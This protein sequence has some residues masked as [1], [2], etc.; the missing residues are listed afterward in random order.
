MMSL[1]FLIKILGLNDRWESVTRYVGW[2]IVS[3]YWNLL[4]NQVVSSQQVGLLPNAQILRHLL[5]LIVAYVS[6]TTDF[7]IALLLT[8][9]LA[10]LL[11][12]LRLFLKDCLYFIWFY[13][14]FNF[15]HLSI[16]ELLHQASAEVF[17]GEIGPDG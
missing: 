10:S 11:E 6:F 12:T 16:A 14:S 1:R 5:F 15:L 9:H 17:L 2:K 8:W 13:M 7:R 3:E 4:K